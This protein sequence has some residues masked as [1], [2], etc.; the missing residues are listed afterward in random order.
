ME[1]K[2]SDAMVVYQRLT[3]KSRDDSHYVFE[4][5]VRIDGVKFDIGLDYAFPPHD[6]CKL[7]C[8]IG[9]DAT[10]AKTKAKVI[11]KNGKV[12][13]LCDELKNAFVGMH[14]GL[15]SRITADGRVLTSDND[16][17]DIDRKGYNP[18]HALALLDNLVAS[19][20]KRG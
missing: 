4:G 8:T 12:L 14:V 2:K 20:A 17:M 7:D 6:F 9:V 15:A 13:D 11:D 18:Q 10:F 3:L 19:Y 16:R 5:D 1:T